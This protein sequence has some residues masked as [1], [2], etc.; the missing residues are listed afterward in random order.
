[1]TYRPFASHLGDGLTS[2]TGYTTEAVSTA[3]D[4]IQAAIRNIHIHHL[5]LD[6]T[7]QRAEHHNGGDYIID[8]M[9][10]P[11]YEMETDLLACGAEAIAAARIPHDRA[12]PQRPRTDGRRQPG[13]EYERVKHKKP[14]GEGTYGKF[15]VVTEKGTQQT[16]A[17][18]Q[19]K[20]ASTHEG[21]PSTLLREIAIMKYLTEMA[22]PHI[23][24]LLDVVRGSKTEHVS[25]IM[26]LYSCSLADRCLRRQRKTLSLLTPAEIRDFSRQL[27]TGV[28]HCHAA[29]IVHRDLKPENVLIGTSE[30]DE[31]IFIADL[32]MSR[33][34]SR[35]DHLLTHDVLTVNYAAPEV[36]FQY[37][38]YTSA[39]DMWSVG[40]IMVDMT[41]G[42][43]LFTSNSEH[44]LRHE[45]C[46][47]LGV[48]PLDQMV[49]PRV[50]NRAPRVPANPRQFLLDKCQRL[51]DGD[52]EE[53][54]DLLVQLLQVDFTKRLSAADALKH[55]YFAEA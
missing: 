42:C 18:K 27:L 14:L 30:A 6:S 22:T 5:R 32:G 12:R 41:T 31:Q 23:V 47:A 44:R 1:M 43:R 4:T 54:A 34:I 13:H 29:G 35:T 33:S 26:P 50:S 9:R 39:V 15:I 21:V 28:R 11:V 7:E 36:L 45:I 19:S 49:C 8:F 55:A 10:Q 24:P 46:Q 17:Q 37:S 48:P 25:I 51:P 53:M 40:C 16:Y 52:R 20:H 3:T 38:M 2:I